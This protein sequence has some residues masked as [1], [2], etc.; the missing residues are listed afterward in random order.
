[1]DE[2]SSDTSRDLPPIRGADH[3]ST[4]LTD[5]ELSSAPVL[6]SVDSHLIVDLTVA[7]HDAFVAALTSSPVE[8]E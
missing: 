6:A 1:M 5:E 7:E 2:V 8:Q 4:D 3:L